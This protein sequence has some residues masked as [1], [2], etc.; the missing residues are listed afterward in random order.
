M[1]ASCWASYITK[2]ELACATSVM[3][4]IGRDPAGPS[5]CWIRSLSLTIDQ[6]AQE[7]LCSPLPVVREPL[8]SATPGPQGLPQGLASHRLQHQLSPASDTTTTATLRFSTSPHSQPAPAS[9]PTQ[10]PSDSTLVAAHLAHRF[11]PSPHA[12]TPNTTARTDRKPPP[13]SN[14]KSLKTPRLEHHAR[15]AGALDSNIMLAMLEPSTRT[16]CSP[17]WSPRRSHN[18][19][20]GAA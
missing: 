8:C 1:P 18:F 16:S 15:H 5:S 6:R 19:P 3:W 12:H 13:L 10:P 9:A 7:Q 17:C 4:H 20:V 14:C 11:S 2:Q